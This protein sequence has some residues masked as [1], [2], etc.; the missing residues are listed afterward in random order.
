MLGFSERMEARLTL[1]YG[2][3]YRFVLE[4]PRHTDDPVEACVETLV[5]TGERT[6]DLQET[7]QPGP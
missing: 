7:W 2:M 1:G 5:G 3:E 6:D 4:A